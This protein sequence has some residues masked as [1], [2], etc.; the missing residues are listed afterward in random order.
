MNKGFADLCLTTWLRRHVVRI[1]DKGGKLKCSNFISPP[2]S[3]KFVERETRFELATL[4]LARRCSTTELLPL[5]QEN[6][7]K[8][9]FSISWN[10]MYPFLYPSVKH[11]RRKRK[12]SG[13]VVWDAVAANR[14]IEFF[15]LTGGGFWLWTNPSLTEKASGFFHPIFSS[16]GSQLR[17]LS[18]TIVTTTPAAS[19]QV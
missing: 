5:T 2:S 11:I 10:E 16:Q 17:T 3:L 13:P 12:R 8:T 1:K 14:A 18:I 19:R 7:T 9:Q 15:G 4:A 6:L